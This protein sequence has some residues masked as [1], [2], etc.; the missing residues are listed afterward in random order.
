M[1]LKAA[2]FVF[3]DSLNL[4]QEPGGLAPLSSASPWFIM[5]VVIK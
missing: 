4:F 1:F 3:A 5:F 2:Y